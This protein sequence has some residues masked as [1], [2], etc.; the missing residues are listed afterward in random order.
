M[1]AALAEGLLTGFGRSRTR[2]RLGEQEIP[3]GE[4]APLCRPRAGTGLDRLRESPAA[5]QQ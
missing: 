4:G 1:A 2:R 3:P 5:P